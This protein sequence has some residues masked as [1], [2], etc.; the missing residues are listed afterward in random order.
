MIPAECTISSEAG[1]IV[2][3]LWKSKSISSKAKEL[4]QSK[5]VAASTRG[6]VQLSVAAEAPPRFSRRAALSLLPV[7][8]WLAGLSGRRCHRGQ[9]ARSSAEEKSVPRAAMI[10]LAWFA[11]VLPRR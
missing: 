10:G 8:I 4:Q 6:N 7:V 5:W 1:R 3:C 2:P 11:G 9:V